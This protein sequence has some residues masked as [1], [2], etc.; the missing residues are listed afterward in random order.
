MTTDDKTAPLHVASWGGTPYAKDWTEDEKKNLLA[1]T[2]LLVELAADVNSGGEHKWPA[3]HGAAE[4]RADSVD[5]FFVEKGAKIDVFDESRQTHSS[6][7]NAVITA[8]I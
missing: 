8:G 5:Q 3:L 1:V 7:A 4:K 6:I 2:R